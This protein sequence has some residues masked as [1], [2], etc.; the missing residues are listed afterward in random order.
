MWLELHFNGFVL[1]LESEE[2]MDSE[3][4]SVAKTPSQFKNII[5]CGWNYT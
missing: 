3:I 5:K 1:Q 2:T 4:R